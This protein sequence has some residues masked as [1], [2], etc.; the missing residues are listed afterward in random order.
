MCTTACCCRASSG[1]TPRAAKAF[2]FS[3][4]MAGAGVALLLNRYGDDIPTAHTFFSIKAGCGDDLS[5]CFGLQAIF[6]LSF[7]MTLFFLGNLVLSLC[8]D[9]SARTASEA[10]GG[11]GVPSAPLRAG[12]GRV[13][14]VRTALLRFSG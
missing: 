9:V 12:G 1:I 3:F 14:F 11:V 8:S 6:R 13:G 5:D 10:G 7:A 4:L 2:Y